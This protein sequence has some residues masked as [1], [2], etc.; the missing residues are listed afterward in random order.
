MG[1]I[2]ELRCK[3]VITN[4]GI[5][6]DILIDTPLASDITRIRNSKYDI[7]F[8]YGLALKY[9]KQMNRED[10]GENIY[11]YIPI[12]E[13]LLVF[14]A[15]AAFDR[16]YDSG[17]KYDPIYVQNKIE[18][19]YYDIIS[20]LLHQLDLSPFLHFGVFCVI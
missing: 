5:D 12:P 19:D 3:T 20:I 16:K 11:F 6:V 10:D 13:M 7:R 14:K 15:K 18:K 1:R 9:Q 4:S 8:Q 2:A 17:T